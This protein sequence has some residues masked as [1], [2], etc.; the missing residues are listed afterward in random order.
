MAQKAN[1]I[2]LR[3]TNS[4][5]QS[6][7][8]WDEPRF[9]YILSTI[10]KL[11]ESCCLGTTHYINDITVNKFL[12]SV[13]IKVNFI[14]LHTRSKRRLKSRRYKENKLTIKKQ[15]WTIV[16]YRLQKAIKLIQNFTGTKK[17][18]IRVNRL[19]TYTRAV[20]KYARK[21]IA[22]YTKNFHNLKY[23]YAR[24]GIQLISLVVQNKAN[25]D[26]LCRFIEQNVC[27]R[28]KRKR[29]YEFLRYLKQSF[30]ALQKYKKIQGLKIQIKGRF[31]HKAKGRSRVW[32]YQIGQMPLS[33]LSSKIQARYK[34]TQTGYGG[35]GLKIWICN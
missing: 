11:I 8:H 32:K 18:T 1:P 17:V 22:Y 24:Y 4:F 7:S 2:T 34:Q 28:Q 21:Q 5:Y 16:A 13:I 35:V 6:Y 33:K 14:H 15:S 23:D 3:P 27:S 26:S 29:H 30:Q 10:N 12:G 25:A 20:P 31:T 9:Y 19:K